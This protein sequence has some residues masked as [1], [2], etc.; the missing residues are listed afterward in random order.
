[1]SVLWIRKR[2]DSGGAS[3]DLTAG[4]NNLK[5]LKH[6]QILTN[7]YDDGPKTISEHPDFPQPYEVYRDGEDYDAS[8]VAT[9]VG[10]FRRDKKQP[11]LWYATVTYTVLP[12][13]DASGPGTIDVTDFLPSVR[14]W[15]IP[16]EEIVWMARRQLVGTDWAVPTES[17]STAMARD[18]ELVRNSVNEMY[19]TG[20]AT[21]KHA[22]AVEVSRY[23]WY[24][25]LDEANTY[26]DT[27]NADTFWDF[28]AGK[29]KMVAIQGTLTNVK[30]TLVHRVTY[31]FHIRDDGWAEPIPDH[32]YHRHS[33]ADGSLPATW[34]EV[35]GTAAVLDERGT[36]TGAPSLLDGGGYAAGGVTDKLAKG[37]TPY[38]VNWH[39]LEESTFATLALPT[40]ASLNIT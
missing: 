20:I 30:N 39:H 9:K 40:K 31:E 27:V 29:V 37:G 35:T 32:G 18:R 22:L 15:K 8:A 17:Y 14:T 13:V 24:Y 2:V 34:G 23:E 19:A 36:P 21:L 5:Y 3:V 11:K 10:S 28:T 12:G 26:E 25:D 33:K 38:M 6:M 4:D 16:Y 7:S 1:V